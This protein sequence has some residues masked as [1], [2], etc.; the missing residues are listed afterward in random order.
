M[1][2]RIWWATWPGALAM[3]FASFVLGSAGLATGLL[4]VIIAPADSTGIDFEVQAQPV[5]RLLVA[6]AQA[7]AGVVLPVLTAFWSRKRWAGYVLVGLG[8]SVALGI[9]GLFQLG[10]L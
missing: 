9:V 2:A 6:V 8:L 5:W 1:S 7:L 10:I 3:G 4:Y